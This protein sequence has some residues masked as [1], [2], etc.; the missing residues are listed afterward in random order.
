MPP[1]VPV[2]ISIGALVLSAFS[3]G[4]NIYRDVILRP[5]LRVRFGIKQIAVNGKLSDALIILSGANYGPGQIT[6]TGV[7]SDKNSLARRFRR[8]WRRAFVI[9]DFAHPLCH[10]LP[11]RL[12][13]AEE[14]NLFFPMIQDCFLGY[15]PTRV[16]ISDSFG[17]IHWASKQETREAVEAFLK[18]FPQT[19]KDEL[20]KMA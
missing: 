16:G 13:M 3:L 7:I 18:K 9:P 10:K 14:V 2:I 6:C 11:H 5:R 17:R 19:E 4:W 20:Q 15:R 8:K 12:N 1:Y